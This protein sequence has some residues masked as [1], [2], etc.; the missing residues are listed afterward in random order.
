MN[1]IENIYRDYNGGYF[2]TLVSPVQSAGTLAVI[3]MVL[4]KGSEPPKH[5][6]AHEDETFYMLEGRIYF[7][8]GDE[9]I[10]IGPGDSAFAP[11]GI[12]HLFKILDEQAKFITII[13]P[14]KFSEYFIEFSVPTM[15]EPKITPLQGPPP[16]EVI[17][18]LI[19]RM[20]NVYGV[21][22]A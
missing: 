8:I 22:F 14:G 12:P 7:E 4:P 17:E 10:E 19:D 1:T 15:G 18:L 3:E 13:S 9:Q 16:P 11:R 21:N 5:V 2:K 6:H 20:V